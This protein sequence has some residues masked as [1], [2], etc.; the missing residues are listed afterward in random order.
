MKIKLNVY[1]KKNGSL[2]LFANNDRKVS[3]GIGENGVQAA[4]GKNTTDGQRKLISALGEALRSIDAQ[5]GAIEAIPD[6]DEHR[7]DKARL[8]TF[9][10]LYITDVSNVG[11]VATGGDG[12]FLAKNGKVYNLS[13]WAEVD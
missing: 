1:R 6:F 3:V 10:D 12:A 13:V 7:E 5:G 8:G 11:G 9:G 2:M 4:Y